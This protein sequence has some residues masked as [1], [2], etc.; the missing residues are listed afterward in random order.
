MVP[1]MYC[2]GESHTKPGLVRPGSIRVALALCGAGDL[3]MC[4]VWI[5]RKQNVH[6]TQFGAARV[7]R[8][9]AIVP[10]DLCD[11][12]DAIDAKG[13]MGQPKLTG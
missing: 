12:I 2:F 3:D 5:S 9:A 7:E 4:S 8:L 1:S 10:D 11:P 6:R 13:N